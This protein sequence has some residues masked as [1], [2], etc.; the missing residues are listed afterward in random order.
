MRGLLFGHV[1]QALDQT[2]RGIR[3]LGT[4]STCRQF[5]PDSDDFALDDRPPAYRRIALLADGGI[6]EELIWVAHDGQG[7]SA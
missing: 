7:E 4:P 2:H 6:D 5:L 3:V 1:H